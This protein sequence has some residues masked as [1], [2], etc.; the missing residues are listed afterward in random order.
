MRIGYLPSATFFSD[1]LW[2]YLNAAG[3]ADNW[4]MISNSRSALPADVSAACRQACCPAS[5]RLSRGEKLT[6]GLFFLAIVGF[7][8]VVEIRGAFLKSRR[9]DLGVFARAAWAVRSGND[10]YS[11]VDEKGL[12]YHYPPLL[13]ILLGPVADPP[14]GTVGFRSVPFAVTVALWYSLSVVCAALSVHA[15]ADGLV[16]ASPRLAA[17]VG[18]ARSRAWWSLR[19]VPLLVCLPY[20]GH[21]LVLGQVNVF[22]MGLLC[23]LSLALLRKKQFQAGLWLA[24]TICLKV[25]P[26]FLLVYPLW[27]RDWRCLSGCLA[28][29]A[30]GLVAVPVAVMGPERTWTSGCKWVEVVLLPG[31][32]AGSDHSRDQEFMSVWST[33]NQALVPVWHKTLHTLGLGPA[34]PISREVR[35]AGFLAG[36]CLTLLTLAAAGFWSSWD[37]RAEIL[38]FNLLVVNML[39]LCPGGHAHYLLVLAPLILVLL[40]MSWELGVALNWERALARLLAYNFVFAA[41]P[42]MFEWG[43]VFKNLGLPMYGAL[44]LW[45]VGAMFLWRL[46]HQRG[47]DQLS[48][49]GASIR[50]ATLVAA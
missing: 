9:T 31:F 25:A 8:I 39:V 3:F 6:L 38:F 4:F 16:A 50:E 11:V 36:A 46:R 37:P 23:G 12:H 49:T 41:V 43:N 44:G 40:A 26:V 42:F 45:F 28:G 2:L 32:G 14:P 24:A 29:L 10:L 22:W 19:A 27:R 33:H 5:P 13:A 1:R 15:L 20:L 34:E 48:G 21:S 35:A 47:Q 7:G 17:I 30:V 18:P